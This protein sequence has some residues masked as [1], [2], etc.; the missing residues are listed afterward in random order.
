MD[1]DLGVHTEMITNSIADLV[2]AGVITNRKKVEQ[3]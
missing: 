3:R 2:E 1:K